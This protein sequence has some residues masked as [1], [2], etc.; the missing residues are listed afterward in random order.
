MRPVWK[1]AMMHGGI[2]RLCFEVADIKD[3]DGTIIEYAQFAG[4]ATDVL[5]AG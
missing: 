5:G 3:P 4:E 1:P 2:C